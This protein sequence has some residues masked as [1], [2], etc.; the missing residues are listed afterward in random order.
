MAH[1]LPAEIRQIHAHFLHTPAS[2]ARYGAMLRDL[3]WS[4]SAHAKDIWTSPDWEICEKLADCQWLTVCS[5]HA[6]DH[7]L[8]IAKGSEQK[9]QLNYHGIDLDRFPVSVR[10]SLLT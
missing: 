1:E 8:E 10:H 2:V 3:P 5:G 7:L 4:V 6:R 9:V